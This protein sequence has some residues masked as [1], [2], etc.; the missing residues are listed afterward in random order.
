MECALE[1]L[2]SSRA[3]AVKNKETE[4]GIISVIEVVKQLHK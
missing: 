1:G 2:M 4:I 3:V